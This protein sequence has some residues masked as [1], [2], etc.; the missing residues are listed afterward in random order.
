M[1]LLAYSLILLSFLCSLGAAARIVQLII[2]G[3]PAKK[4][5]CAPHLP[6]WA[7]A[8]QFCCLLLASALLTRA[9]I[10]HDFSF[11]YVASYTDLVLPLFYRLTAFWGGQEG[12]LLFWAFSVVIFG[13]VFQFLP[14][15]HR[16]SIATRLWFWLFYFVIT[17]FFCLLLITWSNPF[18]VFAQAPT[19]GRG[20]NPMLQNP[21]MIFHPPLLFLGYG[22]FVIPGCLALAQAMSRNWDRENGWVEVSRPF[23]L[24]AWVLLTAG[25]VLGAWW[26]Y[27]ELGWGGYWAWDPVENASLIP[28][29]IATAALHPLIIQ[30]RRNKLHRTNVFL[31]ALTTI[32]AFFATYLVRSGVVQSLHAFGESGVGLPLLIFVLLGTALSL[33]CA[34][35]AGHPK[36]EPFADL[37]T[38]EGFIMIAVWTFLALAGI[39]LLATLA[40]VISSAFVNE[41]IGLDA[42]F[43]NRVCLPLFVF[44]TSLLAICPWLYWN[45]GV[46]DVRRLGTVAGVFAASSCAFWSMGYT[47]IVAAL[48]MAISLSALLGSLFLLARRQTYAHRASLAAVGVHLGLA[49]VVLGVAFSGP[50]KIEREVV[51]AIGEETA[52]G[53]FAVNLIR[54]ND[55][56]TPAYGFVQAEL[57]VTR[58]GK[59]L[60]QSLPERR[61][62]FK[63]NQIFAE[64]SVIPSLGN[65]FYASLLAVDND[66]RATLL[67]S[68]HPLI[69][70]IWIGS[71]LMCIFPLLAL[72]RRKEPADAEA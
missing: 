5:A 12:S 25:I 22:G 3:Q 64:S 2:R 38:R 72:R 61:R 30:T 59:P 62:Y 68:A 48:G 11:V 8:V 53:P 13:I 52:V 35:Q 33:W 14:S 65:E 31:M 57:S 69:N 71:T 60:G 4:A 40:P 9:L 28:W 56:E 49:L 43:Y 66:G 63:W 42:S 46:R 6:E 18:T 39:I 54:I 37:K 32:S 20:L 67:L 27:M 58:Q 55:G 16:L 50:Y 36:A 21:G 44:I 45:G 24:L 70:W 29:L 23:T 15:Y 19:D 34:G 26:S 10:V 41:S 47:N 1:H 7:N 51:L 17:A